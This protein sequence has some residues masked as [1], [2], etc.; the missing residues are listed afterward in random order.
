LDTTYISPRQN[1]QI[2]TCSNESNKTI[3]NIRGARILLV[4]DNVIN[5]KVAREILENAGL[6]VK[7]ANNGKEALAEIAAHTD[8][9]FDAILMDIQ[10][11]EMDGYKATQFIRQQHSNLPIIAMT[12]HAMSGDK[13]KCLAAD[14][15]DYVSK[16]ID[17]DQLF[18]TLKKWI[19]PKDSAAL[20]I[21]PLK[22]SEE[23][24]SERLPDELPGIHIKSAL[25][26]L[27]GNKKLFKTLLKEFDRD[28]QN[29]ADDI[30]KALD[31]QDFKTVLLLSHT[32]KGVAGNISAYQLQSAAR[33]LE[34]AI[35]QARLDDLN[36]F[37]DKVQN[38]LAQLLKSIQSIQSIQSLK[39]KETNED[40]SSYTETS[41]DRTI[42]VPL[43][44][45]LTEIIKSGNVAFEQTLEAL[46]K[47]LRG[48][49]FAK[50]LKQL[51]ACLD[52]FDFEGAKIPLDA[53]IKV[54]TGF[55]DGYSHSTPIGVGTSSD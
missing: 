17:V 23:S 20:P 18:S 9:E 25:N 32:L 24:S 21:H 37:I 28:Y 43:L 15:N 36:I 52:R 5:Q 55:T 53:I 35:E 33:D 19:K 7:I 29:A 13:K 46:I 16:P 1:Q 54:T 8:T 2:D 30:S 6:F 40:I 14:M 51:E 42:V 41:L 49:G 47:S 45:E 11:P 50:E 38:A 44:T 39:G 4:E 48:I 12:A 10:M 26:R 27:G 31:K 22:E 3:Q 34:G